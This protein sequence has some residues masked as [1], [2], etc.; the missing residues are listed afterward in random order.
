MLAYV[1]DLAVA[2][3]VLEVEREIQHH[4]RLRRPSAPKSGRAGWHRRL[5]VLLD[6]G[7]GAR[8]RRSASRELVQ[9]AQHAPLAVADM[10]RARLIGPLAVAR[11][12][13]RDDLAMLPVRFQKRGALHQAVGAEE[14]ELLHQSA[15]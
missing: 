9:G 5:G 12:Q 11:L 2:V 10:A 3:A 13:L 7:R 15:V 1:V 6:G 4:S 14:M 8:T